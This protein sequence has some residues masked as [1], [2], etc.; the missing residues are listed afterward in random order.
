MA[1]PEEVDQFHHPGMARNHSWLEHRRGAKR[2]QTHH[3]ADLQPHGIAIWQTQNVVEEPILGVPHLVLLLADAIHRISDPYEMLEET[4][5][6]IFIHGVILR[7]S[8]G[9]IKHVLAVDGHPRRAICLVEVSPFWQSRTAIKHSNI[10][11]AEE[12]SGEHVPSLWILAVDPPVEIQ[13]ETLKRPLQEANI[14]PAQ[15]PFHVVKKQRRPCM[16]RGIHV[17]EIPLIGG[18]LPARM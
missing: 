16:D 4:I 14:C 2:K 17:T 7:Q 8:K 11:Q 12:S 3:R 18:N 13:H 6:D 5:G 10:I 15:V 9:D 1:L